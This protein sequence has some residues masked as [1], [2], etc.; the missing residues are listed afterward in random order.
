MHKADD[1]PAQRA[2]AKPAYHKIKGAA[3]RYITNLGTITNRQVHHQPEPEETNTT[4]PN[5]NTATTVELT[6]QCT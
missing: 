2:A 4:Q 5:A 1:A 6:H 3:G